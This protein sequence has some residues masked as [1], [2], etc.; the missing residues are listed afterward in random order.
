MKA[1]HHSPALY[2]NHLRDPLIFGR[3]RE[4]EFWIVPD[5]L[6]FGEDTLRQVRFD[7]RNMEHHTVDLFQAM[8]DYA[9]SDGATPRPTHYDKALARRN[10]VHEFEYDVTY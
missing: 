2:D 6:P 5:H 8:M 1:F 10:D 9:A 7:R 4:Q 3:N